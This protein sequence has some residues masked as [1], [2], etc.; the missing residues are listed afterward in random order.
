ME[1]GLEGA[2]VEVRRLVK[3]LLRL[4]R[5][6]MMMSLTRVVPEETERSGQ[7]QVTQEVKSNRASD[8][9]IAL[10]QIKRIWEEKIWVLTKDYFAP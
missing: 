8:R 7:V 2:K 9:K 10:R 1:R 4:S 5:R 3:R 6:Q